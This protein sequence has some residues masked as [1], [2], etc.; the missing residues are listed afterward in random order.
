VTISSPANGAVVSGSVAISVSA[1]DNKKVAQI[2]LL[3]DGKQVALSYSAALS[4]T[5]S[6]S[7]TTTSRKNKRSTTLASGSTH[8][9]QA[10][11]TDPAG[12]KGSGSVTVT[13]Q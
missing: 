12:N 13:V 5:W 3:I 9:I 11:A 2:S 10:I 8:T 6:L 4:Y 7:T 1:S